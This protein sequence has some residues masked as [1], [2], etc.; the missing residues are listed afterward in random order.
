[1]EK[2]KMIGGFKLLSFEPL[3]NE[4]VAFSKRNCH[5]YYSL[6]DYEPLPLG[7]FFHAGHT[8]K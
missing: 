7:Q 2:I 4:I 6:R 5:W 8:V 3:S 1:L